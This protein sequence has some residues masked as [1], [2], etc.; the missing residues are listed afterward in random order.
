MK[1]KFKAILALLLALCLALSAAA[2]AEVHTTGNV[3]L[4]TGPGLDYDS[5]ATVEPDTDL[6][7]LGY[8]SVDERGVAWYQVDHDGPCWI[9]SKYSELDED[10]VQDFVTPGGEVDAE[11][12][13]AG[14][15]AGV[16][17]EIPPYDA[18]AAKDYIDVAEYYLSNLDEIAAELRLEDYEETDSEAPRRYSSAVLTLGG[19]DRVEYV[20]LRGAG[21]TVCGAAVGMGVEEAAA[22]LEAAGMEPLSDGA[23]DVLSFQHPAGEDS[24]AE[25][26]GF[27]SCIDLWCSDGLVYEISWSTYTG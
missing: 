23:S 21:Y 19:K 2:M 12:S 14:M 15:Y 5:I 6:E 1:M 16:P 27:D 8:T 24:P 11:H 10:E 13:D 7:Y 4:R 9:S 22:A 17:A 3:N 25:V 20:V 18:E 26:D